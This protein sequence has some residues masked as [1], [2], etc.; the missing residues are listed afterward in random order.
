MPLVLPD[1][2][3]LIV[4]D[5]IEVVEELAHG[6][7]HRAFNVL[8]ATS[9][10]DALA[11]LDRR[12][13]IGVAVCDIRMPGL[14]GYTLARRIATLNEAGLGTEVILISGH[15]K[16]EDEAI[17]R[18]LGVFSFLRK[19]FLGSELRADLRRALVRAMARRQ[20]PGNAVNA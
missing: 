15:G 14:D 8:T 12:G 10:A 16:H 13:D 17:A 20:E 6:L 2:Q 7:R 19:P 11:V 3:I 9:G 1:L 4:D 18:A 5:E